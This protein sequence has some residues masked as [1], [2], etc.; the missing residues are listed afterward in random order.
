MFGSKALSAVAVYSDAFLFFPVPSERSVAVETVA[1]G[2]VV[3]PQPLG[4][5]PIVVAV[6]PGGN[7][8]ASIPDVGLGESVLRTLILARVLLA[9]GSALLT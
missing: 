6:Q 5:F 2:T 3:Y 9:S 8:L 4:E 1:P 7:S